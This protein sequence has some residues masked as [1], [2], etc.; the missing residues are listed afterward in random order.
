MNQ[1]EWLACED[2]GPMLEFLRGG[3]SEGRQSVQVA[4]SS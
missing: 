4:A 1:H 3:M 2:P